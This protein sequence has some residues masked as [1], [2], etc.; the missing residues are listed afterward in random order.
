V[1]LVAVVATTL[2]GAGVAVGMTASAAGTDTTYYACLKAGVLSKVGT[3][4]P[5]CVA[6]ATAISWDQTGPPGP[7]GT[8]GN[9]ILSGTNAPSS[10]TGVA[11]NFY[12]ETSN[13]RLYGPATRNC[14]RLPCITVWGAGTS[15]VGSAGPPGPAGQ[16]IAYQT[17]GSGTVTDDG[18]ALIA[19]LTLPD[20]Y[21]T[22]DAT[23]GTGSNFTENGLVCQL[24][25]NY[26]QGV[27]G[28]IDS[29]YSSTPGGLALSG[30]VYYDPALGTG[31]ALVWCHPNISNDSNEQ[32]AV[33]V[34]LT[35]TQ[36]S[37]VVNQ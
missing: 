2:I 6:P 5:T 27:D 19:E 26:D 8:A 34:H 1:A 24:S 22:L 29:E 15:L 31:Y 14:S 21:F 7:A 18:Y 9:T 3:T 36:V 32:A 25:V 37:D 12:L 30:S 17:T 4:A 35:A 33:T 16:G 10:S 20:G 23:A 28:S 11:G 13:H